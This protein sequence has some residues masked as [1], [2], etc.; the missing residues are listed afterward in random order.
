MDMKKVFAA[1]TIVGVLVLPAFALADTTLSISPSTIGSG[2]EG[3]ISIAF[4]NIFSYAI[5][6]LFDSSGNSVYSPSNESANGDSPV[7]WSSTSL[8]TSLT[9]GTY[10]LLT[11]GGGAPTSYN[12]F[13][14]VCGV[15][16]TLSSCEAVDEGG[17]QATQLLT[18]TSGGTSTGSAITGSAI[19]IPTSTA[20]S[21][22]APITGQF[23]DPGTLLVVGLV[24]GIP[25]TFYVMQQLIA[26]LPGNSKNRR[27]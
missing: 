5:F 13:N 16:S 2:S 26:L 21:L 8:P 23:S 17:Y 4:S 18:I 24:A 10:T 19:A 27:K 15:G 3:S 20:L 22:T 12:Y 9:P 1:L 6:Y 7:N 25:L 14:T 11:L